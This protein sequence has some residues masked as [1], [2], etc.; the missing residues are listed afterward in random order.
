MSVALDIHVCVHI[1]LLALANKEMFTVLLVVEE[2]D[3]IYLHIC[4]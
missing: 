1:C 2:I 3:F 4:V